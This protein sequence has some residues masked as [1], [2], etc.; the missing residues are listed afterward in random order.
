MKPGKHEKCWAMPNPKD[1]EGGTV[2]GS[3]TAL[4]LK[5]GDS[6]RRIKIKRTVS[7]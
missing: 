1:G 5:D 2:F 7:R 4:I 6:R 3:R